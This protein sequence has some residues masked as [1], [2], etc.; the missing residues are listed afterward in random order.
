MTSLA[1]TG[2][3][4]A[5]ALALDPF[6]AEFLRE[7]SAW[8][9]RLL[10]AG[11]VCWLAPH[12]I[13][14]MARYAQVAEAL[15]D[16]ETYCSSAGVGLSDFRTE[17]P[18]RPPSLL[19]EADPPEHSRARK[20]MGRVLSP[21]TIRDLRRQFAAEAG[22]LLAGVLA[23]G[24]AD[25]VRDIAEELVLRVLPPAVGLPGDSRR[26]KPGCWC[27]PCSRWESSPPLP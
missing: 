17:P 2:P 10:D 8:H 15:R 24:E 9:R 21:R 23:R 16:W 12:R 14:A 3:G 13:W 27:G 4:G 6:D 25:G 11:P 19:L 1:R 22:R 5:S 20:V 26:R 7:P 18:W